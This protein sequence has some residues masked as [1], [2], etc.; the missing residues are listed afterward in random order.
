MD[1]VGSQLEGL[2]IRSGH[3]GSISGAHVA[4]GGVLRAA[5]GEAAGGVHRR[6]AGAAVAGTRADVIDLPGHP[7]RGLRRRW[8]RGARPTRAHPG[9]S[10]G[11]EL[12]AC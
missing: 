7:G 8:T 9:R 11:G 5:A 6:W 12:K 10:G 4:D 3:V 2:D 1:E